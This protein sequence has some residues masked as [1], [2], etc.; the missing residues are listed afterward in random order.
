MYA[1]LEGELVTMATL[2]LPSTAGSISLCH[3]QLFV[4]SGCLDGAKETSGRQWPT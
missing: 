4:V 3:C 2:P 1:T